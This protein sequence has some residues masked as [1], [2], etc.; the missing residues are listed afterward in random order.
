MLAILEIILFS[1]RTVE[2]AIAKTF[3]T[4]LSIFI[5]RLPMVNRASFDAV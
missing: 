5:T 4:R 3:A 1:K 2:A